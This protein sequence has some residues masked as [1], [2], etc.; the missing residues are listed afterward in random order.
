MKDELYLIDCG[1]Y[2]TIVNSNGEHKHHAHINKGNKKKQY[3]SANLLMDL[4]RKKKVPR[5]RYFRQS[6]L[7]LTLD[8]KYKRQIRIKIEKDKQKQ[9]YTNV[10]G[11]GV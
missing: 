8:E 10:G 9:N 4:V 11:R 7:R 3:R 6:A 1:R 2:I 5:S